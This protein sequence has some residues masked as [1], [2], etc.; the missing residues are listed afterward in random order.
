M[1]IHRHVASFVLALLLGAV[2]PAAARAE[3]CFNDNEKGPAV[4]NCTDLPVNAT[5]CT[6]SKVTVSGEQKSDGSFYFPG[7]MVSMGT[8][9][10][11]AVDVSQSACITVD[12]PPGW[13][14]FLVYKFQVCITTT[15]QDGWFGPIKSTSVTITFTGVSL[16]SRP[17]TDDDCDLR[18]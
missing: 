11:Q 6:A 13:C 16:G 18:D 17:A 10:S 4:C 9:Y 15:W 12:I 14:A 5:L 2:L 8:K 3:I 1:R 7:F